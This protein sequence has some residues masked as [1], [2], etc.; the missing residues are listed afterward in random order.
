MSSYEFKNLINAGPQITPN[1][2]K[3]LC[4]HLESI[5]MLPW[6]SRAVPKGQTPPLGAPEMPKL[7]PQNVKM[8]APNPPSGNPAEPKGSGGRGRSP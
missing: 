8:K 1:S 5:L 7:V 2:N 3:M 4:H 6:F